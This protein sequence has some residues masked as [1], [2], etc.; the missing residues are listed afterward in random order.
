MEDLIN[1]KK[2]FISLD[3]KNK[4]IIEYDIKKITDIAKYDLPIAEENGKVLLSY[5]NFMKMMADNIVKNR[6]K[7]GKDVIN[8]ETGKI[9]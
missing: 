4:G 2:A 6:E 3:T 9:I 5:D 7:F 1:I 8:Y